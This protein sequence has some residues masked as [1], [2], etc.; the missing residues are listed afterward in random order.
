[1][2]ALQKKPRLDTELLRA[3]LKLKAYAS[4]KKLLLTSGVL[5]STLF[6]SAGSFMPLPTIPTHQT[7]SISAQQSLAM[8]LGTILPPVGDWQ[9]DNEKEK[10]ISELIK[11]SFGV[12][13]R[14][15]LEGNRLNNSYGRMG[16]EQH[17]ARFPGDVVE[18]MALGLGGCGY[19]GD[20]EVEKYYV[21]VQTLYLPDWKERLKYYVG[22]YRF[23]KMVIVNPANGKV[24]VTAV[25]DAGPSWWTGKHFGGSPEVMKYLGID[26]GQQ[27]HPVVLFFLDDPEGKVPLGPIEYNIEKQI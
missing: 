2:T 23:R 5:A 9:L 15:E 16:A 13:A 25:A 22:W 17:L 7:T 18:N 8:S 26:Y 21:A 20:F 11:K 1:M 19:V 12:N 4:E 14:A 24:M 3:R 27:N 10:K 6:L